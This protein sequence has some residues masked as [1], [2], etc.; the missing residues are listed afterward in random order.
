MPSNSLSRQEKHRFPVQRSYIGGGYKDSHAR[1]TFMSEFP[2][3]GEI[4]CE[5]QKADSQDITEAIAIAVEA[6]KI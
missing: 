5:L 3:T 2:A 6:Q 1:D 4:L